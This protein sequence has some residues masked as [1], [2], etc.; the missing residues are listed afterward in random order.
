METK[1]DSKNYTSKELLDRFESYFKQQKEHAQKFAA[2]QLKEAGLTEKAFEELRNSSPSTDPRLRKY[3]FAAR[4]D[5][6][7][8]V[9]DGLE[10]DIKEIK[11]YKKHKKLIKV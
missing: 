4:A 11:A 6:A 5:V 7:R 9:A 8:M 10:D 1:N 3:M 2:E